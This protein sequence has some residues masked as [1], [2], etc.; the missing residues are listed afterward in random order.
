M[1]TFCSVSHRT[2]RNTIRK[3]QCIA[4]GLVSSDVRF[5]GRLAPFRSLDDGP[6]RETG[7]I[8]FFIQDII[9]HAAGCRSA[10]RL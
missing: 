1:D 7:N 8:S 10:T 3:C 2:T 9:P 5:T 6:S 4:E